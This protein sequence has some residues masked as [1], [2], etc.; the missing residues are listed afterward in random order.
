MD[1]G[2]WSLA[3]FPRTQNGSQ[4]VRDLQ[5]IGKKENL[6]HGKE[7]VQRNSKATQAQKVLQTNLGFAWEDP[8]GYKA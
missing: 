2:G 1:F 4:M 7:Q 8:K 6:A 5:E 3:Y